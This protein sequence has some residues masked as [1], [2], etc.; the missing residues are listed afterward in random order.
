MDIFDISQVE[1]GMLGRV[2]GGTTREVQKLIIK[3]KGRKHKH[4]HPY[5]SYPDIIY[6]LYTKIIAGFLPRIISIDGRLTVG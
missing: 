3:E 5:P 2:R 1:R 6:S 4:I